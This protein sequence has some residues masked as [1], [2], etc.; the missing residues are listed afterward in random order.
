MAGVERLERLEVEV[1]D[2]Q[3]VPMSGAV[4][5]CLLAQLESIV[6]AHSIC[7]ALMVVEATEPVTLSN[8]D[9]AWLSGYLEALEAAGTLPPALRPLCGGLGPFGAARR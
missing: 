3:Q 2:G 9:R 7:D 4:R 8:L 6:R 1:V 5:D